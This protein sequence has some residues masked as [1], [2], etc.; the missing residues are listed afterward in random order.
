MAEQPSENDEKEEISQAHAI[1]EIKAEKAD[2]TTIDEPFD[3][4][5]ENAADDEAKGI[6]ISNDE[7]ENLLAPE[8]SISESLTD[9]NLDYL[10][11]DAE[12]VKA[13][14][15]EENPKSTIPGNLQKEIKSVLSYMDQLLENLPEDKIA[16]FAQSEQF[17]TYKK[18]FKELGLDK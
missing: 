11:S 8:P 14:T 18:L 10:A 16:E 9:A 6:A 5:N 13:E 15:A 3:F 17:E 2:E 12:I 7:L 1:S 4:G